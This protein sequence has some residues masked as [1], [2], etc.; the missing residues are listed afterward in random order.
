MAKRKTLF[1]AVQKLSEKIE[2]EQLRGKEA[3]SALLAEMG[4]QLRHTSEIEK[5]LY[6]LLSRFKD[7]LPNL[8]G[9]FH[10]AFRQ[11]DCVDVGAGGEMDM[12]IHTLLYDAPRFWRLFEKH[13]IDKPKPS[14]TKKVRGKR[15]T[16]DIGVNP[17]TRYDKHDFNSFT[18]R[19]LDLIRSG[20][21]VVVSF[22]SKNQKPRAIT[23]A[24]N[25]D[26]EGGGMFVNSSKE[27]GEHSWFND[28]THVSNRRLDIV[29]LFIDD[30]NEATDKKVKDVRK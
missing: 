10:K 21:E 12:A 17:I 6:F 1:V 27:F 20:Y 29:S 30:P 3:I 23:Y 16:R 7:E 24:N 9:Y 26:G 13:R 28:G 2:N 5:A 25:A 18:D 11:C 4:E 19:L 15:P 8:D 22:R 14:N